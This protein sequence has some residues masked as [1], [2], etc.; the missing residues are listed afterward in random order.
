MPI[1]APAPDRI[2]MSQRER[3]TLKIMAPVLQAA[4]RPVRG[5]NAPTPDILIAVK[6]RTFLLRCDS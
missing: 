3:D 1:D 6:R 2:P 5:Q 4:L